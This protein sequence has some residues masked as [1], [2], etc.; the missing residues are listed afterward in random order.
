[1]LLAGLCLCDPVS[2]SKVAVSNH[3][4]IV[5]AGGGLRV[6]GNNNNGNL[7]LGDAFLRR[8]FCSSGGANLW[9]SV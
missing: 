9:Q 2:A 7:G 4:V 1:M 8:T 6:S 3:T 5:T